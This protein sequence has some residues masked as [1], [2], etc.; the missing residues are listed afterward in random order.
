MVSHAFCDA[1]TLHF[2]AFFPPNLKILVQKDFWALVMVQLHPFMT[3]KTC[4]VHISPFVQGWFLRG[5]P[6]CPV[7]R[8]HAKGSNHR[9]IKLF[10]INQARMLRFLQKLGFRH[11]IQ[12][13]FPLWKWNLNRAFIFEVIRIFTKEEKKKN[14]QCFLLLKYL[15]YSI[16]SCSAHL[17]KINN[18]VSR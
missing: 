16:S 3:K 15:N 18:N 8:C 6:W 2:I 4:F 5:V 17:N 13:P 1:V 10:I 9:K 7:W 14:C 12:L 11:K